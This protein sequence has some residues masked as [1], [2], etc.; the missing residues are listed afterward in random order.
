[1]SLNEILSIAVPALITTVLIPFIATAI[2]A[3][4]NFL[5][6]KANNA[7]L[8]KYFDMANDAVTT[9]VA[10]VMQTFVSEMKKAG[11]WDKE[12][13]EKAFTMAR[14]KAIEIMGAAALTVLPEIVG[15]VEAW[16]R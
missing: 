7:K 2:S 16:I 4:T 10:E 15:D 1:M 14:T 5:K 8:D 6:T 3:L 11:T 12:T 9:A 13:A